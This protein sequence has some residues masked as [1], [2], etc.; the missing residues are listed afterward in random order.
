MEIAAADGHN[1]LLTGVPGTGKTMMARASSS[2]SFPTRF[3]MV[4][5]M[6]PFPCGLGDRLRSCTCTPLQAQRYRSRLSGPLLDRIDMHIKAPPVAVQ[7]MLGQSI[8]RLG[9]SARAN[10][11]PSKTP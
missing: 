7:E 3:M 4:A 10:H 9:L 5:A 6:N 1:V 11:A 2:L 8:V